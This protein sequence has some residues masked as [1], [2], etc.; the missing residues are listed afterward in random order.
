LKYVTIENRRNIMKK[1]IY[2][3]VA[4]FL[5]SPMVCFAEDFLGAP[6]PAG[7]KVIQ[8][9]DTKMEVAV[10]LPYKDALAFYKSA[11]QG[12]DYK[13]KD[14]GEAT[15]VE[16]YGARPWHSILIT[17]SPE[18]SNITVTKD[19]WTWI[20]G[21]L[22]LRFFAVFLVLVCLWIPLTLIGAFMKR[23]NEKAAT[24]AA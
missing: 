21:T 7:G 24:K 17:S 12:S 19:S 13:F 22:T 3:I 6:L 10:N 11:L 8:K 15:F 1:I 2:M 20:I 9:T 5:L 18:G 4:L 16:E 14:R 23:V